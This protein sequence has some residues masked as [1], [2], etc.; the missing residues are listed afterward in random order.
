MV[1]RWQ[2]FIVAVLFLKAFAG[3]ESN[4]VWV[5]NENCVCS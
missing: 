5:L 2:I 4:S 3:E 1:E